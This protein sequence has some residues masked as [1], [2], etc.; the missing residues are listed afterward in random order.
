M[1]TRQRSRARQRAAAAPHGP[2]RHCTSSSAAESRH[3]SP[4]RPLCLLCARAVRAGRA[5]IG[6]KI[7]ACTDPDGYKIVFVDNE[8]FLKELK[9]A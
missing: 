8:D 3:S 2:C 5:G 9:E 1:A 4:T 6:T 7:L